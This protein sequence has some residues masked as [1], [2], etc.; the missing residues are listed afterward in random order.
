MVFLYRKPLT[1]MFHELTDSSMFKV[2][3]LRLSA[4][5]SIL[6]QPARDEW[7]IM[8]EMFVDVEPFVKQ[9][10]LQVPRPFHIIF[11]EELWIIYTHVPAH[12]RWQFCPTQSQITCLSNRKICWSFML[13]LKVLNCFWQTLIFH[14]IFD[15]SF[16]EKLDWLEL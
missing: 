3:L 15:N 10:F 11:L 14:S 12:K 9:S 8:N 1:Y 13:H 4:T 2:L 6:L 16:V 5:E 7:S